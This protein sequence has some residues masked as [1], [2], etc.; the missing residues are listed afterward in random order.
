[1][2]INDIISLDTGECSGCTACY[3]MCPTQAIQMERDT[4]GFLYPKID[5]ERCIACELCYKVC[6]Q[7]KQPLRK[8]YERVGYAVRAK[9]DN[10]CIQSSSGGVF[11]LLATVILKE[12]G[13]V[14]GA[15]LD[16]E[17]LV[18]HI[19]IDS[20]DMLDK[21]R[22]SK[23]M[24]S[25]MGNCYQ[26]VK[27]LLEQGKKVLF[28][29][30]PCQIAG[31]KAFLNKEY[32]HLFLIDLICHGVPSPMVW[33][34]YIDERQ[35]REHI[36]IKSVNFRDKKYGWKEY[37][38]SY[39]DEFG[40]EFYEKMN[41]NH[42]MKGFLSDLYLRPSCYMCKEKTWDKKSDITLA[43]FW[44]VEKLYPELVNKNG[45]S[46]VTIN[47]PKG[48]NI[49][50]GISKDCE[51]TQVDIRAAIQCNTAAIQSAKKN[52]NREAFFSAMVHE[53][54]EIDALIEKHYK[55]YTMR[56]KCSVFIRKKIKNIINQ[57][58][59]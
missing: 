30:T 20:I 52:K 48:N 31:L 22:G 2:D 46:L 16:D 25:N 26:Y 41:E 42:F 14:F 11:S 1:M 56:K 7:A 6:I 38:F 49:F 47:T 5:T 32:D 19:A 12:N 54:Q 40:R 15:V 37:G 28:S 53:N 39:T 13:I 36:T 55:S 29:G 33:K 9:E 8:Q 35:K 21:L 44:G 51:Y 24:Q 3:N 59:L 27:S 18:K 58:R 23:Y 17:L 57:I 50:V 34:Q 43:D 4:E 10:L 45:V